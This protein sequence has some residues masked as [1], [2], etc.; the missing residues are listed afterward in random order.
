ME[1]ELSEVVKLIKNENPVLFAK[2]RFVS[3][4]HVIFNNRFN[5]LKSFSPNSIN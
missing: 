3:E 5:N 4:N 1:T 2:L